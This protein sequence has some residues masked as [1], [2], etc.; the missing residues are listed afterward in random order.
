M[1]EKI[2][3]TSLLTL[4]VAVVLAIPSLIL[5]GLYSLFGLVGCIIYC[6]VMT[7]LFFWIAED[8]RKIS[9]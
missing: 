6:V 9:E 7:A 1:K 2:A 5:I 3:E 8:I 4:I